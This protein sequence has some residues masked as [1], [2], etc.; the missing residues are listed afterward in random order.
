[1][2]SLEFS[3]L[4][5]DDYTA[6]MIACTEGSY[7]AARELV[8]N[9]CDINYQSGGDGGW[10]Y[11]ALTKA[12]ARGIVSYPSFCMYMLTFEFFYIKVSLIL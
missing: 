9:K 8:K 4:D 5:Y 3:F 10:G 11:C 2:Y 7:N 1:M 6:L 12:C